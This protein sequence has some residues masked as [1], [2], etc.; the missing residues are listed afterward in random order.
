MQSSRDVNIR[1]PRLPDVGN[2][3]LDG[4][5]RPELYKE[6]TTGTISISAESPSKIR[7]AGEKRPFTG[8]G[9]RGKR[10]VRRR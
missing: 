10:K 6:N 7:R 1:S 5:I 4:V 9:W 2:R 3:S 8:R